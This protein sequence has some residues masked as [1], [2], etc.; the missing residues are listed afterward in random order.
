MSVSS[1]LLI[2]QSLILAGGELSIGVD[3]ILS[4]LADFFKEVFAI[5]SNVSMNS[6]KVSLCHDGRLLARHWLFI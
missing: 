3:R 1:V 2:I 5:W 6:L 4:F